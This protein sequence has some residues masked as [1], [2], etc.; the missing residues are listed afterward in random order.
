MDVLLFLYDKDLRVF[1][2]HKVKYPFEILCFLQM[3]VILAYE[4]VVNF[5]E[6]INLIF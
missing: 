5:H 4:S 2:V 1:F 3:E 6:L